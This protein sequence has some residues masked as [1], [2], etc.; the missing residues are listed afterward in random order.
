[1][2]SAKIPQNEKERLKVLKNYTI[3]DTLPEE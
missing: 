1:M 2:K 3:L